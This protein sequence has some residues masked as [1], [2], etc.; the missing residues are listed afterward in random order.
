MEPWEVS[1]NRGS[2]F[3]SLGVGPT[4]TLVVTTYISH[5]DLHPK[6]PKNVVK[7]Q[8][9]PTDPRVWRAPFCLPK[10]K[11]EDDPKWFQFLGRWIAFQACEGIER[12]F[13]TG[14]SKACIFLGKLPCFSV[15]KSWHDILFPCGT[16]SK[17]EPFIPSSHDPSMTCKGEDFT[18]AVDIGPPTKNARLWGLYKPFLFDP[19]VHSASSYHHFIIILSP[20]S[21]T[22]QIIMDLLFELVWCSVMRTRPLQACTITNFFSGRWLTRLNGWVVLSARGIYCWNITSTLIHHPPI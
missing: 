17:T 9:P 15:F 19:G 4:V 21:S 18:R 16:W 8:R 2:R 5:P 10:V 12:L 22:W 7:I 3:H 13:V 11:D 1:S 20:I 6:P 14:N